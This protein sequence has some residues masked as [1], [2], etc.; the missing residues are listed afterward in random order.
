MP[1]K[2]EDCVLPDDVALNREDDDEHDEV[3]G[4]ETYESGFV[5]VTVGCV[6]DVPELAS[7]QT[8]TV[9]NQT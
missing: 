4:E 8:Y 7:I 3:Q 1:R 6:E 9:K 2:R 5:D